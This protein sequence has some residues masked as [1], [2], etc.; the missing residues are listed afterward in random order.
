MRSMYLHWYPESEAKN[1]L[2]L[3]CK[4]RPVKNER[5]CE[6]CTTHPKSKETFNERLRIIL[7]RYEASKK[8][9]KNKRPKKYN[10]KRNI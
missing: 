3:V 1:R 10:K 8:L 7:E 4:R 6:E 9:W 2:C 5:F